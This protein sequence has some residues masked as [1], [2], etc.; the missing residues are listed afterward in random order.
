MLRFIQRRRFRGTSR[1]GEEM[2]LCEVQLVFGTI[3]TRSTLRRRT[4]RTKC[5]KSS[6]ARTYGTSSASCVADPLLQSIVK[7]LFNNCCLGR[8]GY[9]F[10]SQ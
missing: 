7:R 6:W 9:G 2:G 4:G 8:K 1:C 5:P 10:L 3:R